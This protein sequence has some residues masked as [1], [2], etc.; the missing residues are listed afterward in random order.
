VS[1]DG[2]AR[3]IPHLQAAVDLI[4]QNEDERVQT[5][6]DH[7][8]CALRHSIAAVSAAAGAA[9]LPR[10][11]AQSSQLNK[12]LRRC[13][14]AVLDEMFRR[15]LKAAEWA[16]NALADAE[17]TAGRHYDADRAAQDAKVARLSHRADRFRQL[18]IEGWRTAQVLAITQQFGAPASEARALEALAELEKGADGAEEPDHAE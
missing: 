9:Y 12:A 6:L 7:I 17:K 18:A 3:A 11:L 8:E 14:R 13:M 4:R 2:H 16:R 10:A 1:V 15:P 5:A